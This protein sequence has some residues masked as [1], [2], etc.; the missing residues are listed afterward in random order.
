VVVASKAA[1][2]ACIDVVVV[3]QAIEDG[4]AGQDARVGVADDGDVGGEAY[5]VG[6]GVAGGVEL[7]VPI[8]PAADGGATLP[9]AWIEEWSHSWGRR[10]VIHV[11]R[12]ALP[13]GAVCLHACGEVAIGGPC[14]GVDRA[15]LGVAHARDSERGEN[16]DDHDDEDEFEDGGAAPSH[17]VSIGS[18][19]I[20]DAFVGI[21]LCGLARV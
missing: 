15:L 2:L 3:E 13:D 12:E 14:R 9:D 17:D 18:T 6:R 1:E 20:A 8:P 5:P 4:G 19:A 16:A 21:A 7:A 10:R 11:L